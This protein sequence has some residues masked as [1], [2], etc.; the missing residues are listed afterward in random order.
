MYRG[1][2]IAKFELDKLFHSI[3][4][5]KM[6]YI[7]DYFNS[8]KAKIRDSLESV[9]HRMDE[10]GRLD[11]K[12]IQQDWFPGVS[13]HVFI[14]HSHQDLPLAKS[15][16]SWLLGKFSITSFIDSCIWG[17]ADEL[18]KIIDD[19]YCLDEKKKTYDYKKRNLSTSHVHMMLMTA[20]S[21]MIDKSECVFFLNTPNSN[22]GEG[23]K[24]ATLSPWIY[25]EI[26]I[27]RLIEKKRPPRVYTKKY[28]R[29][30]IEIIKEQLEIQYPL[31]LGHFYNLSQKE[32]L[33]WNYSAISDGEE[34]LDILYK[35]TNKIPT[36]YD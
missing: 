20:L 26:E 31:N 32:L 10:E 36:L 6:A 35:L 5:S 34:A 9:L 30:G 4:Y 24:S 8:Q 33:E 22:I 3:G 18:L 7:D 13:T 16:A 1:Y 19:K 12:L 21:K 15:F 23:I 2:N 11:G 28:D 17:Y 27:S 29:G 25:G 14:S